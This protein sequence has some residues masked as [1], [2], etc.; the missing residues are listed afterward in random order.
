MLNDVLIR[1]RALVLRVI[2]ELGHRSIE[3]TEPFTILPHA[4]RA[5]NP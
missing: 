3:R 1:L 5:G 2:D 4:H